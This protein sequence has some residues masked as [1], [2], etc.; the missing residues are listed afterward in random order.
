MAVR[1]VVLGA[2]PW[3]LRVAD[4]RPEPAVGSG[5]VVV[6]VLGVGICG[7]DLALVSGARRPPCVP[8]VPGHEAFGEIV[9]AG[10]GV[11]PVRVGQRVI[12]EPNYPCLLCA[13]CRSGL[14]SMCEDR[15]VVGFNAP[16][17][18]G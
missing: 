8:W 1:A 7:S 13:A 3:A 12:V 2:A 4:G 14:T 18:A 11:D 6:R 5:Q 15:V 9:A 10:A 16:G 17:D